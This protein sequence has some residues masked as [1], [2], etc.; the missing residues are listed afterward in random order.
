MIKFYKNIIYHVYQDTT[1]KLVVRTGDH[2]V[3]HI[4]AENISKEAAAG[5][6]LETWDKLFEGARGGA[7]VIPYRTDFST[8]MYYTNSYNELGTIQ[9][10]PKMPINENALSKD[11]M[12]ILYDWISVGAPNNQGFIKFSDNSCAFLKSC[13]SSLPVKYKYPNSLIASASLMVVSPLAFR[14]A[15]AHA[16]AIR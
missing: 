3:N 10:T 8:F 15:T 13:F 2:M 6:S 7:V 5:L 16:I 4:I 9:L 1:R 11:E 14:A 12:Q